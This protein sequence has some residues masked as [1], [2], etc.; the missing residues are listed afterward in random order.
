MKVENIRLEFS[1]EAITEIARISYMLNQSSENIGARRLYTVMEKLME[2]LSFNAEDLSGQDI[3]ID[4]KY[5]KNAL[6]ELVYQEDINK[7]IL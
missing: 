5:V 4:A 7:F 6:K 2:D 1:Q 3:L